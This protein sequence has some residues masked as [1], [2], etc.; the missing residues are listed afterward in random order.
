MA[1]RKDFVW[2]SP[3]HECQNFIIQQKYSNSLVRGDSTVAEH[4]TQHSEVKGLNPVA[5]GE[6]MVTKPVISTKGTYR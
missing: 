5:G 4:S 3:F 2:L 6:I 1:V